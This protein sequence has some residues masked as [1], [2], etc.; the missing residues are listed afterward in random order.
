[1]RR[2]LC[3]AGTLFAATAG[4]LALIALV[5]AVFF[6]IAAF[7]CFLFGFVEAAIVLGIIALVLVI[8][9]LLVGI[10]AAI[11]AAIVGAGSCPGYDPFTGTVP[12]ASAATAGFVGERSFKWP[13]RLPHPFPSPPSPCAGPPPFGFDWMRL[14]HCLGIATSP[15]GGGK[16]APFPAGPPGSETIVG[17]IRWLQ[18][19][20]D[21]ER[22]ARRR[23]KDELKSYRE[24]VPE[25]PA[26]DAVDATISEAER[27]EPAAEDLVG[28]LT[29]TAGAA[30]SSFPRP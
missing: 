1:M 19:R 7:V 3:T 26:R 29:T 28:L 15:C 4:A 8:G 10:P 18:D 30:L 5:L 14:L 9:F 6:G 11:V 22:E 17:M 27:A 16:E 24:H 2:I 25:G 23:A 20:V 21:E 13:F 12:A